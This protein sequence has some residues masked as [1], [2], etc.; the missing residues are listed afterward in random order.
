[1]NLHLNRVMMRRQKQT[2]NTS[3]RIAF[4]SI[5]RFLAPPRNTHQAGRTRPERN[6]AFVTVLNCLG[7]ACSANIYSSSQIKYACLRVWQE[8]RDDPAVLGLRVCCYMSKPC[9]A[10]RLDRWDANLLASSL[11]PGTWTSTSTAC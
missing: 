4:L 2:T 5:W 10:H 9:C 1:M 8:T 3:P 11:S 6:H 7:N